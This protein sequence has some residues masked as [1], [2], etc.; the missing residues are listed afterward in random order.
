MKV[1]CLGRERTGTASKSWINGHAASLLIRVAIREALFQLG[2]SHVYH[3]ASVLHENP[4]DSEMWQQAFSA[5]FEGHG[6]FGKKEWDQ[7]LGYCM[8][9]RE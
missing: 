4:R 8:V 6:T 7:L 5:K 1:L 3:Y 9:G 2:H